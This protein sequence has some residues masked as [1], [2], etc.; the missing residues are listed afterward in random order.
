MFESLKGMA[1]MAGMLRDLPRIKAR[2]AEVK[3]ELERI[4]VEAETGGGAVRATANGQMRITSV[5]IDHAMLSSL[6]DASNA[7]D[8]AMAEDLIA[9]AVNAAL[10]RAKEAAAEKFGDAARELNLPIP[11]GGLGGLLG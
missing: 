3:N 9:G 4:T 5:R 7:D 8:R 10:E 2:M 6:V 1:G 11:A